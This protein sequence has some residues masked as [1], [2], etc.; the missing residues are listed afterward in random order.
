MPD[1]ENYKTERIVRDLGPDWGQSIQKQITEAA[2][3]QAQAGLERIK[4]AAAFNSISVRLP[5][6][7]T[8]TFPVR[9]GQVLRDDGGVS[10]HCRVTQPGV[11]VCTGPGADRCSCGGGIATTALR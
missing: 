1:A 3:A 6:W 5:M 10:C 7:V 4:D 9:D 2:A 8:M 11:C